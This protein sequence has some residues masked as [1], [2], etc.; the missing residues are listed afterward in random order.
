VPPGPC[1]ELYAAAAQ[2]AAPVLNGQL[3][4]PE[5]MAGLFDVANCK[6]G[7]KVTDAARKKVDQKILCELFCCCLYT[8]GNQAC[9]EEALTTADK[10]TGYKSRYKAEMGYNMQFEPPRPLTKKDYGDDDRKLTTEPIT[11]FRHMINRTN[12]EFDPALRR[13]PG[14]G[15]YRFRIADVVIVKDPSKPPDKSNI[16]QVIEMKFPGDRV[17]DEQNADYR[18][19][20]GKLK[21]K[22]YQPGNPCTC[23]DKE[24]KK[25]QS[26]VR[27]SLTAGAEA[28]AVAE[29]A[30]LTARDWGSFIIALVATGAAV[31]TPVDGPALDMAAAAAVAA[32][33]RRMF[34]SPVPVSRPTAPGAA[35]VL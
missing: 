13:R 12:K 18:K 35:E 23:K 20:G 17:D 16:S 22:L 32:Q 6:L 29:P 33:W 10:A 15:G 28:K 25:E 7:R 26:G 19:I 8:K 1:V 31:V 2:I 11:D 27:E 14:E 30:G 3:E 9:V 21:F 34:G 5:D 24:K 4:C